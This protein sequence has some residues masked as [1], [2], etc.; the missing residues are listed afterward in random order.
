MSRKRSKRAAA[1]ARRA[2]LTVLLLLL[3]FGAFFLVF[4]LKT[5]I[6]SGNLHNAPGEITELLLERPVLGNTILTAL[7]NNG[8]KIEE[9]GFVDR[10]DVSILSRERIRVTVTERV[11][12]GRIRKD[13]RWLYFDSAGRILAESAEAFAGDG[14][15]PVEGLPLTAEAEVMKQLP[16]ANLKICSMLGMLRNRTEVQKEMIP[17][18]VVFGEDGSM[19][20][21]YGDV[22]VLMGSGEKLEMRLK[23]LSGVIRA[24]RSGYRGTLHLET[25]DGSQ[26]GLV[27]DPS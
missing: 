22:S 5:V 14:I 26:S 7:M 3:L 1:R 6:V 27:F 18:S 19:T 11:F 13:D 20:L 8:R 9:A 2:I 21:R 10:L 16:I 24:L 23:E 17:D 15:P 4:R 25:Y 12:V